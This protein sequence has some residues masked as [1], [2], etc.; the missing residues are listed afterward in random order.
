MTWSV[1]IGQWRR[2]VASEARD[3]PHD[4]ILAIIAHE[5]GGKAGIPSKATTKAHDI[6]L[7]GGGVVNYNHALGLMQVIPGTLAAYNK[8]NPTVFFEDMAGQ[9]EQAARAQVR[10]GSSVYANAIRALYRYDPRTF[11]GGTP[12][13]APPDQLMLA[14]TAYAFGFG[15]LR[16]K[17]DALKARGEPLT[18]NALAANFPDWGKVGDKW[19]SRPIKYARWVWTNAKKHGNGGDPIIPTPTPTPKPQPVTWLIPV[20]LLGVAWWLK[21]VRK[22]AT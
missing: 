2:V 20:V 11:P 16:K 8:N 13:K 1:K 4:L 17:L 7:R 5:S 19:L 22:A 14:L 21:N 15:R 10:V 6:P 18:F 12:G 3:I 9:D